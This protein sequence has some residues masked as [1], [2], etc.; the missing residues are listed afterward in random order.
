LLLIKGKVG[1][2]NG[3]EKIIIQEIKN[4]HSCLQVNIPGINL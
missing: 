3:K 4:L 1:D 2:K